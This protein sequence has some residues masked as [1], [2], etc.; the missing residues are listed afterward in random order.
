MARVYLS[1]GSN[2]QREHHVT[3]ALDA[4][5]EQF[6]DLDISSVYD[7]EA[8]GFDGEAFLNLVVGL[9][10]DWSVSR[11]Y[12]WIKALEN[13]HGRRRDVPRFSSRTLD[14]DILT[15]D[16]QVGHPAGVELPRGEI[17]GNAFVLRPLAEIA[18]EERHPLD[19]R[20]Y[21]DLWAAYDR[22]QKLHPIPFHWHG[23]QI[24][25]RR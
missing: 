22:P 13:R 8:V 24:S 2:Q 20:C 4:L 23:R 16:Q 5:R 6:G 12:D 15:V 1:I 17:L 7:S 11:L 18:P 25:P 21:G 19:G 3:V 10:T 14:I 9:D